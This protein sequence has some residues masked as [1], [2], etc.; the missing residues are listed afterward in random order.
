[1]VINC[2]SVVSE[3]KPVDALWRRL[4]KGYP[5]VRSHS[6]PNHPHNILALP[7]TP[8]EGLSETKLLLP[9]VAHRSASSSLHLILQ[10]SFCG[11]AILPRPQSP[12]DSSRSSC[13]YQSLIQS[14]SAEAIEI[15]NLVSYLPQLRIQLVSPSGESFPYQQSDPF[16]RK[17][18]LLLVAFRPA[19]QYGLASDRNRLL[20]I[21]HYL[22][23]EPFFPPS[24]VVVGPCDS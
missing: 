10:L 16:M 15:R 1:V 14:L 17:R 19:P 22:M 20:Q 4:S 21:A 11:T 5:P 8:A 24:S 7:P 18:T 2:A 3:Q 13:S 9:F 6:R 23:L 12:A